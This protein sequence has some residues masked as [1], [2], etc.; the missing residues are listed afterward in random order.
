MSMM[1]NV[2]N[3]MFTRASNNPHS[4]NILKRA[5]RA[6]YGGR[7]IQYG[8]SISFSHKK[9]RRT[10]KPNVQSKTYHSDILNQDIKVDVTTYTM[11]CIDK[12]GNFDNYIIN[13]K[14]K[15]LD[16]KLGS[17]LK[18]LLKSTLR[19]KAELILKEEEDLLQST[20]TATQ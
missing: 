5:Q 2:I 19:E 13:T 6:L 4:A 20:S 18:V 11:R 1:N 12:A 10:W 3:S 7:T 9:T 17:D 8:N 15:D 16:S 14:D